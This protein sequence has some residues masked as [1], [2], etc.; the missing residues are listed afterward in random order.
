MKG[1]SLSGYINQTIHQTGMAFQIFIILH[2]IFNSM[3]KIE[4]ISNN[5]KKD[6]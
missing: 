3:H 1:L 5:W 4:N 2:Y 6:V